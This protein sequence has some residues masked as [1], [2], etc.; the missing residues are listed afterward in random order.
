MGAGARSLGLDDREVW[1][2]Y[3]D[4]DGVF[5][6]KWSGQED[7]VYD[8]YWGF[9]GKDKDIVDEKL[10]F[11]DESF[12]GGWDGMESV[13]EEAMR[14]ERGYE[15]AG[16]SAV[17]SDYREP[18]TY[19]EMLK[20][21]EAERNKWLEGMKKEFKDFERRKVWRRVKIKDIP[22]GRKLVGCKWVYKLKRNG[23]Y[24]SRLVALGYTQV[25]G[26]DFTDNV[27]P[28][29]HD[30][31]LRAALVVWIILGLDVDQIDVETAFLEGEL[32]EKERVFLKCPP[33]M[34][35]EEDE[36]LE[37]MK[38]L[39][40][41]VQSSR[42][43][44]ATI[45]DFLTSEEVGFIKSKVDQ[46][47]FVKKGKRGPLIVLLYVDDSCVLG[48]REDIDELVVQLRTRF[49]IKVEGG[50]NDFLGCEILREEGKDECW[51]LQYH[52]VKK[53]VATFG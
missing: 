31:T 10:Q 4:L 43:F 16:Y 27:S 44:W 28:V 21:P 39:Y 17:E 13:G 40:G 20:R 24:R 33:G 25:P 48:K 22:D 19:R 36:C 6:S 45:C 35:M 41:L 26:V 3:N 9:A 30:V 47:L 2:Y 11:D 53:L 18:R 46:C 14:L 37:I 51:I 49:T 52:L 15:Q 34:E 8:D 5:W 23:V 7:K 12:W 1:E 42:L 38:G 50:L 32:Q 29:V